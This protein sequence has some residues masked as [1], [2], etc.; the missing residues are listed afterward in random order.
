MSPTINLPLTEDHT[1]NN[2][3][4]TNLWSTEEDDEDTSIMQALIPPPLSQTN[5]HNNLQ[6]KLQ[7]LIEGANQNWTYAVFWLS[8]H[9]DNNNNNN[10]NNASAMLCWGDGYYKGGE[11]Y[12]SR[13][14]SNPLE[15]EHR[16]RVIRELNSLLSSGFVVSSDEDEEVTDTEWFFLVSMTQSFINGSGLPSQAFSNSNTIWLSGSNALASSCCVR[17]C[18]GQVYGLETM[19][20]VPVMNGVVELGS[21]E[22]IEP[23]SDLVDK[24]NMVFGDESGSWTFDQGEND[25]SLWINEPDLTGFVTPVMNNSSCNS[26][27]DQVSKLCNGGSSVENPNRFVV[28]DDDEESKN[29]KKRCLVLDNEE[30][31]LSFTSVVKEAGSNRNVVEPGEKKPRKRGRK[32]ANGR[33][34][35]LNHVEAERQRREKL[36]QKFY[37]LRAV[38]PNVSKMDKASLLGDAISYIN[39][40]KSNLE[41][42]ESDKEELEKQIDE[43]RKEVKAKAMASENGKCSVKDR[44][45]LNQDSSVAI[46][47]EIDVKIIGWDVMVRIQCSKKN[48]PGAR[49]ME[50]LKEL[51]MEVNHASLSVMND[52]MIQQAT[53]KM[54]NQF[55]TQ[56]QLKVA[57]MEKVGECK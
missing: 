16:K 3:T 40:L 44:K 21:W 47:M 56:D 12:K 8:S 14:K 53:V 22:I 43:M 10:N 45:C 29:K 6:Q 13:K 41:K 2:N 54:G 36:N 9:E 55:F 46:E 52:L 49:F 32:P 7:A 38:V 34:E 31:M 23:N 37:A 48:H 11:E 24:V 1:L 17:A 4:S 27:S 15:Q 51:D 25:P 57:L 33:E 50:A 5:E 20:C 18:Q 42:A 19:V 30:G 26:D 28:V 35:P 39:E